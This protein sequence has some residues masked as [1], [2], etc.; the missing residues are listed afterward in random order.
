[1]FLIL[2]ARRVGSRWMIWYQ[3]IPQ[4]DDATVRDWYI[5]T[6]AKGDKDALSAMTEPAA[7]R[8]AR[9]ALYDRVRLE[10]IRNPF[11]RSTSDALVLKLA[12]SFDGMIFLLVRIKSLLGINPCSK[13]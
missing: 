2:G 1:M 12:K 9:A 8:V 5:S 10:K 13:Y 4:I 3:R 11:T 7:L 6:V